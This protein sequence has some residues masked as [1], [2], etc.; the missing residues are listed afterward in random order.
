MYCIRHVQ[1]RSVKH[2]LY[3]LI[4]SIV[5]FSCEKQENNPNQDNYRLVQWDIFWDGSSV[6]RFT[7]EY[8]DQNVT[9][10]SNYDN[11]NGLL[12]EILRWE[13]NYSNE[14]VIRIFGKIIDDVYNKQELD[15]LYYHSDKLIERFHYEKN[16]ADDWIPRG[17]TEY[18]Y[19]GNLLD[20]IQIYSFF[21]GVWHKEGYYSLDY[22]DD[23]QLTSFGLHSTD[24][25]I[26][27]KIEYYYECG[28][29]MEIISTSEILSGGTKVTYQYEDEK[30][31]KLYKYTFDGQNWIQKAECNLE[32]NNIGLVIGKRFYYLVSGFEEQYDYKYERG[33][34]FIPEFPEDSII[35]SI[36][37]SD[38]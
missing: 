22:N 35:Y 4:I 16:I 31:V 30:L 6:T 23:N 10:I 34:G 2:H 20:K 18:S 32:Y 37:F 13:Y 5:L 25:Y 9:K 19:F 27:I 14:Y 38:R 26:L 15:S 29:L 21:E 12:S 36:P 24:D 28:K 11:N 1:T 17:K 33:V 3:I 7:Y 8:R